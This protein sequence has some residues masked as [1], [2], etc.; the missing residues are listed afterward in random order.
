MT[1]R[2]WSRVHR[3]RPRAVQVVNAYLLAF[4]DEHLKGEQ[5]PLLDGPSPDYPEVSIEVREP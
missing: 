3:S 4:F 5:S 1:F 2:T